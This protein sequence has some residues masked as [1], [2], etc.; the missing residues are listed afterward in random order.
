M[1]EIRKL[2]SGYKNK[3]VLHNISLNINPGELT[4]IIGPNGCGK[5]TLMKTLGGI[6]KAQSGEII[7]D[8]KALRELSPKEAAQKTAYLPQT[9]RVPDITVERLVLH[10]RYPFTGFPCIYSPRDYEYCSEAMKIMGIEDIAREKLSRLSGG[11]QQKAY[12]AMALCQ[13]ADVLLADE[14]TTYLDISCRLQILDFSRELAKKGKYV[15][16]VIHDLSDA[17]ENAD[18]IVLMNEGEI[19]CDGTPEEVYASGLVQ[20]VF[21]IRLMCVKGE[22]GIHY[23]AKSTDK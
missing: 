10:G 21:G 22:N 20:E 4:A 18:R 6:I 3:E 14:P 13:D 11:Q 5:S 9:R 15:L 8:S 1:L 2:C 19:L 7:L 23:F 16:M 12:I 17:F